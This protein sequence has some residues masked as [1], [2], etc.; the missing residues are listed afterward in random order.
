MVRYA[1]KLI[2]VHDDT[3][4]VNLDFPKPHSIDDDDI[5]VILYPGDDLVSISLPD[6]PLIP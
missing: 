5:H 6:G 2:L 1:E 4:D 3:E